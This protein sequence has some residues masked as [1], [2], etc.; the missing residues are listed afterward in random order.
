M[1]IKK[2]VSQHRRDFTA[3]YECEACGNEERAGGYD[4]TYF[5]EN[6]IP[7]MACKSCGEQAPTEHR[8]LPTKY[9]DWMTV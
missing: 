6:V 7:V 1:R 3:I 4:D 8:P 9:P 5:H 2:I